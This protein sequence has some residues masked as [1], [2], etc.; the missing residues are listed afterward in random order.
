MTHSPPYGFGDTISN[1]D[2]VGSKG[3]EISEVIF[4]FCSILKKNEPNDCPSTFEPNGIVIWFISL[5]MGRK[6]KC[7]L[8]FLQL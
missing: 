8:K 1:G 4:F 6:R 5:N 2:H 7:L 3:G